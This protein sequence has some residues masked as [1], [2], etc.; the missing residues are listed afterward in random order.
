MFYEVFNKYLSIFDSI[1]VEELKKRQIM[2]WKFIL[3]ILILIFNIEIFSQEF[4]QGYR[5]VTWDEIA[6]MDY[7]IFNLSN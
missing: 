3:L 4:Y 2:K 1:L 6:G 5:V 7:S